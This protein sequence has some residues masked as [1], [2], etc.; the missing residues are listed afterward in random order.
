MTAFLDKCLAYTVTSLLWASIVLHVRGLLPCVIFKSH[1]GKQQLSW[2]TESMSNENILYYAG[3]YL[4]HA[5]LDLKKKTVV[6]VELSISYRNEHSKS[7]CVFLLHSTPFI[8]SFLV[9]CSCLVGLFKIRSSRA[10]SPN[11]YQLSL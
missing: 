1:T 10:P 8:F 9:G 11:L 4:P 5:M 6:F 3:C 2:N 7:F